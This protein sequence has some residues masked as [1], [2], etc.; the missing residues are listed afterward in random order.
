MGDAAFAYDP[1][2]SHGIISAM[3]SGYYA[4]HAIADHLNVNPDALNAY[5]YVISQAFSVYM[6]MHAA[7][8]AMEGR[9]RDRTFWARR[10]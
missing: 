6:D 1:V 8:Y 3:E 5:D 9:W 7:H 2:S 10:G 4:G